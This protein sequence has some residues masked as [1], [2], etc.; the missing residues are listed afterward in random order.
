MKTGVVLYKTAI[1][2]LFFFLATGLQAGIKEDYEKTYQSYEKAKTTSQ[3]RAI[4]RQFENLST[5]KD[6]GFYLSNT[7]YWQAECYSRLHE[8][9]KALSLFERALLIPESNKEEDARL[10]VAFCYRN[11][12]WKSD[13]K[14]E[15]ERF[16]RDFPNSRH[17]N[18]VKREIGLLTAP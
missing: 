14:W 11:M 17:T 6:V 5:R 12:K 10:K 13:A 7:L 15:F 16:L 8:Y 9:L 4:A 2:L 18:L 3:I 1:I